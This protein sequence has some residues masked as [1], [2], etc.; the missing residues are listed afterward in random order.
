M[1][2]CEGWGEGIV[3]DG[4]RGLVRGDSGRGREEW[5]TQMVINR[6]VDSAS[7]M[8]GRKKSQSW[9]TGMLQAALQAAAQEGPCGGGRDSWPSA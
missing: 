1:N 7:R 5:P 3:R 6:R 4:R 2:R 9:A 8:L